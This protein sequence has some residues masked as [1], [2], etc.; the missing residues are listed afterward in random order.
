MYR[1]RA[2]LVVTTL[3]HCALPAIAMGIPV[4]VFYPLNDAAGHASD[5]ERFS[6]LEP[7][8]RVY[9]FD[10]LDEVDWNPQPVDVSAIKLGA[11]DS[12]YALAARWGTAPPP[13]SGRS[14]PRQRLQ[15]PPPAR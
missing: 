5:R 13:R 11:L 8:V 9:R 2:K 3:L 12:F 4:V 7:I 6:S 15:R 14:R 10:E 1:S